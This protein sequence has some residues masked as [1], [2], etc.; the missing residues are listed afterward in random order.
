MKKLE[1]SENLVSNIGNQNLQKLVWDDAR[2][3]LAVARTGTLSAAASSLNIGIATLSRRVDRLEE[4]LGIP[5]FIR[6]QS[7]YQLTEDGT[8]L[9][10]KAEELEAA[11]IAFSM[12]GMAQ[13]QLTGKVRLATA[14]NLASDLIV[15]ALHQFNE[16]HPSLMIE[17]I[18]DVSTVNV[19]RR[20]ADLAIRMVKPE[21]GNVTLRRLGILGYGLYASADYVQKRQAS[22]NLGSYETDQFITWGEVQAHLPA[23]QWVER[24]LRGR[25]PAITT[26]SLSTQ[27]AA[28]SAG[29]GL[30]LIPHFL[31]KKANLVCI[32]SDIGIDQPI[33]LVIQSDLAQSRRIRALADFLAELVVDNR[34]SLRGY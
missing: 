5:L 32:D 10:E 24:I 2:A 6:Q 34:H 31:A 15:P 28:A 17:I 27:I 13:T 26:T 23:A 33:Y 8:N 30:A 22:D 20:D 7:G 18:T 21:R 1:N 9:V 25:Q 16:K 12:G 4:A 14:E 19:H 3:F 11:A 29:L